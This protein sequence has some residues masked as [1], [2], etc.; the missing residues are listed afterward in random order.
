MH[1]YVDN[2]LATAAR[3]ADLLCRMTPAEKVGRCTQPFCVVA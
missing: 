2:S 3:V 1:P